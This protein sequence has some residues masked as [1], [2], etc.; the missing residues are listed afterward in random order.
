MR[1]TID[2]VED[3]IDTSLDTPHLSYLVG[4]GETPKLVTIT[5]TVYLIIA[6]AGKTPIESE[7]QL[8]KFGEGMMSSE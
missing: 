2:I 4:C 8:I 7:T 5:V 6:F 1:R 3:I